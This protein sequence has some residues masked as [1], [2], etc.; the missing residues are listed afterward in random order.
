MDEHIALVTAIF[1]DDNQ[2]EIVECLSGDNAQ[3]FVDA[4]DQ[5]SSR[6]VSRSKDKSID[7]DPNLRILS[8]RF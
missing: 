2:I 1:L 4:V 8:I 3:S 5:A 6:T 7:F